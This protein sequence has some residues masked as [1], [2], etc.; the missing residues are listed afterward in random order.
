MLRRLITTPIAIVTVLIIQIV[1][2]IVFPP[3]SFSLKSQ[4]WWLPALLTFFV[5]LSFIQIVVRRNRA[6]WPWYLISFAQGFN[7]ISRLLMLMPHATVQVDGATVFNAA[8]VA[9]TT[10]AM[11]VSTFLLWYCELPEVRNRLLA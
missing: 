11:V 6:L 2:L 8:Y 4:E 3:S 1:P 10:S 9:I 7:I 5:V